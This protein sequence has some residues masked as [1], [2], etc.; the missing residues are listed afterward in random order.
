[1]REVALAVREGEDV[2]SLVNGVY[3]RCCGASLA[4]SVEIAIGC[5]AAGVSDG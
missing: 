2:G 3:L 4:Q 5:G 1:M